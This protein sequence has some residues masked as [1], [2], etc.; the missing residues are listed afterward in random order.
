MKQFKSTNRMPGFRVLFMLVMRLSLVFSAACSQAAAPSLEGMH[1]HRSGTSPYFLHS[2]K[3]SLKAY[4]GQCNL[5]KSV[6]AMMPAGAS[7]K[8]RAACVNVGSGF[9]LKGN[10]A[11]VGGQ[12]TDEYFATA[13]NMS[14]RQIR[15]TVLQVNSV[16][17]VEVVEQESVDIRHYTSKGYTQYELKNHPK[18][19]RYWLRTE[20]ERIDSKMGALLKGAFN[21]SSQSS[22]SQSLGQKTYAGFKCELREVTG[23]WA[24]SL[25]LMATDTPFPGHVTLAGTIVAGNDTMLD[26]KATEVTVKIML[27]RTHFY[28]SESDR[29]EAAEGRS[30]ASGNATQR[31]CQK[32]KLKTGVNPCEGESGEDG[33]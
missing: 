4:E 11:D 23:P 1:I 5:M 25:C 8:D 30:A 28:P 14:A 22:V 33:K 2:A 27:P 18:K 29:V 13:L 7:S 31:W 15:K 19:G 12:E 10:L 17:E 26:E 32:Q 21:L 6:C 9:Q 24:G 3:E 16:C 20:H